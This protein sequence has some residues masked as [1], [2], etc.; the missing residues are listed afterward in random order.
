MTANCTSCTGRQSTFAPTS[1]HGAQRRPLDSLE[2]AAQHLHRGHHGA[3]VAGADQRLH[4]AVLEEGRGD[5][6]RGVLLAAEGV[7]RGFV[8]ADDLGGVH[9]LDRQAL[10]TL[11]VQQ[12]LDLG[13]APHQPDRHAQVAGRLDR[14]GDGHRRGMVPAHGVD[15]Y[16]SF[17]RVAPR[18]SAAIV[19]PAQTSVTSTICRPL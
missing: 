18:T 5:V 16:R 15:G 14:G 1:S 13:T 7:D 12:R 19:A 10:R 17:H 11:L 6:Q 8:H 3:G 9:H 4:L 2:D